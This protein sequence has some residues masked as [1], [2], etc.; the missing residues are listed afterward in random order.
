[1]CPK[2]FGRRE[3][4]VAAA[5]DQHQVILGRLMLGPGD[6]DGAM[7]R[8][9]RQFG[10]AYWSQWNLR[11][12]RRATTTFMD[13]VRQAYLTLLT[14][15]VRCDLKKLEIEKAKGC[16]D[17]ALESLIGEAETL[18]AKLSGRMS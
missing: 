14:T 16:A 9:E 6:S 18:L 8:A 2:E 3:V 17:A 11:H 7:H 4:D 13:R 10:L 12:K 15:S 1:M 5:R